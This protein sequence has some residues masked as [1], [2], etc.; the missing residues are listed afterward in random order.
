MGYPCRGPQRLYETEYSIDRLSSAEILG[1]LVYSVR[2]VFKIPEDDEDINVFN[3]R[4]LTPKQ[5]E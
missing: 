3:A 5:T 1:Y 4:T 2:I